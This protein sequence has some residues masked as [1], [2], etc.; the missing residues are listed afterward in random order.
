MKIVRIIFKVIMC[1]LMIS[2]IAGV[3]GVFPPP[4]PDMYNTPE[5]FAF[6]DM[7]LNIGY[8]DW[9]IAIVF[10]ASIALIISGRMAL[11]AL[12]MLPVTVNIIS[13]HA[14][15]DGGLFTA[16]AVMADV[17]FALNLYFLWRN[18]GAYRMLWKKDGASA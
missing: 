15:L 10:A 13:F 18:R 6:I 8:I 1:L 7:L 9:I 11:A 3:L 14:F 4:T 5:A 16:G 12:L 2:P 17:L